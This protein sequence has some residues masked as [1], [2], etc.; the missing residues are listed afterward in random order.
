MASVPRSIKSSLVSTPMVRSPAGSTSCAI[1]MAS[2]LARSCYGLVRGGERA[3]NQREDVQ[4]VTARD[5]LVSAWLADRSK[6]RPLFVGFQT[7]NRVVPRALR[8]VPFGH[9]NDKGSRLPPCTMCRTA[10]DRDPWPAPQIPT[11]LGTQP[12]GA[13][14]REVH[15][16]GAGYLGEEVPRGVGTQGWQ[17]VPAPRRWRSH[18]SRLPTGFAGEDRQK[19]VLCVVLAHFRAPGAFS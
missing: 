7:P 17:P 6:V 19:A 2:E 13:I 12:H 18:R 8:S 16:E 15:T 3:V 4:K 5:A 14:P 11:T 1:L 9:R 10:H